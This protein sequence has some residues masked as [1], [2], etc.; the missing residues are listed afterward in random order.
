MSSSV[1]C[2]HCGEPTDTFPDPGVEEPQEYVEDCVVCCRP[3]RFVVTWSDADGAHHVEV[4]E[5]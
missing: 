2:P 3:I 1:R 4:M 5:A